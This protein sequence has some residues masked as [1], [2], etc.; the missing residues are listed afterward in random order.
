MSRD[1]VLYVAVGGGGDALA[2]ALVA[3]TLGWEPGYAGVHFASFAWERKRDDP[4]VGPR[5]SRDFTGLDRTAP[6]V[7][8]VT[9][10]SRLR[11]GRS[12]LPALAATLRTDIHLLDP[13]GGVEQVSHQLIE[14]TARLGVQRTVLVDAGGDVLARGNEP[15]LRSPL[16]DAIALAAARRLD[17]EVLVSVLGLGLDGELTPRESSAACR[18]SAAGGRPLKSHLLRPEVAADVRE[19]LQWHPSEVTGLLCLAALGYAGAVELRA[20]GVRVALD[21]RAA[22]VH[23]FRHEPVLARNGIARDLLW[24]RSLEEAEAVVLRRLGRTELDDERRALERASGHDWVTR[25]PPRF[26]PLERRL[27][28]Y[29]AKAS[30]DGV[31]YLTMRRVAE[32]LRIMPEPFGALRAWLQQRHPG[33]VDPPVWRTTPDSTSGVAEE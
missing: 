30:R 18:Y 17:H 21:R 14:L 4:R 7:W 27:L 10:R 3:R 6:S 13:E 8:T 24:T 23:W 2:A 9:P 33:R 28:L 15:G 31:A 22:R 32:V 5:T 26:E 11:T 16:A 20:D 19:V 1:E 12:F 25:R 29:S